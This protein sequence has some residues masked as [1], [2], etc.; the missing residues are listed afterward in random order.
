MSSPEILARLSAGTVD[1]VRVRGS[2]HG[3]LTQSDI[4]A[5]MSGMSRLS[6]IALLLKYAGQVEYIPE[7]RRLLLLEVSRIAGPWP[8]VRAGFL[9]DLIN[10]AID[11]FMGSGACPG[12]AGRGVLYRQSSAKTCQRCSGSGREAG[13]SRRDIALH[14]DMPE[15]TF[16]RSWSKRYGEIKF[17]LS[18]A[19]SRG[20]AVISCRLK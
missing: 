20:M 19:E 1:H 18:D 16:R 5:A 13:L 9:T 17:I 15:T 11:D 14:I 2:H 7:F 4:A 10:L 8:F 6:N 3:G 12:C